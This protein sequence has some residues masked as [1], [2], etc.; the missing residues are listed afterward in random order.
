MR[1]RTQNQAVIKELRKVELKGSK[2]GNTSK[3]IQGLPGDRVEFEITFKT[4]LNVG[5]D[6]PTLSDRTAEIIIG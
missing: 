5:K 2:W 3:F 6:F 4:L 1:I